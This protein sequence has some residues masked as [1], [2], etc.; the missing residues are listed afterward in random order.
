MGHRGFKGENYLNSLKS[1]SLVQ[2][3]G[4]I[5]GSSVYHTIL[6]LC[7]LTL[8]YGAGCLLELPTATVQHKTIANSNKKSSGALLCATA[9]LFID[10]K[11][12]QR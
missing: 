4:V 8:A 11:I 3:L 6:F 12:I 9:I 2:L 5:I 1:K 10:L 7:S